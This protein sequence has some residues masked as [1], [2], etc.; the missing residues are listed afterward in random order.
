MEVCML[1]TEMVKVIEELTAEKVK[2]LKEIEETKAGR[3]A[4]AADSLISIFQKDPPEE[5]FSACVNV[6]P[7]GDFTW[8]IEWGKPSNKQKDSVFCNFCFMLYAGGDLVAQFRANKIQTGKKKNG[9]EWAGVFPAAASVDKNG[10]KD[11]LSF[12]SF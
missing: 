7:K 9:E 5:D 12:V 11:Y 3:V 10:K 1:K 8:R 2:L 6:K 4:T